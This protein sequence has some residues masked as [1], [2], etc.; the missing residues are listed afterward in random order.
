MRLFW[1]NLAKL[2]S[3]G[4]WRTVNSMDYDCIH[5][6]IVSLLPNRQSWTSSH[7]KN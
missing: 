1:M 5:L 4:R 6:H 2:G 7:R 3:N